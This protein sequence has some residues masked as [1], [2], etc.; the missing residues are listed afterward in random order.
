MHSSNRGP[1]EK[2]IEEFFSHARGNIS[3]A[4][5]GRGGFLLI[6][7]IIILVLLWLGTGIYVVQ[8]AEE[9]VVRTFGKFTNVTTAG[10]NY[11]F[12]WPI[13]TVTVV[14]VESIRRAE[15]G[16]RTT[17][18]DIKQE[19]LS[20]ALMLTEDENIVQVEL[21]IQYR[22]ANPQDFVFNVKRPEQVLLTSAEVALRSAVGQMTID[23]VITEER[24]R[25]QDETRAFLTR[26]LDDYGTGI[27]VT[28]VRLQ[29]ADPPE[30]VRDAFQEVVRAKADKERLINEAQ[31][32]QNDVVPRARGLKQQAIEEATAF[33]EQQVLRATGDAQRFLSVLEAYRLAP[34][35]TRERMHIEAIEGVLDDVRLVLLDR[36]AV[37]DQLLPFLPLTDLGPTPVGPSS[38]PSEV[39]V[40]PGEVQTQDPETSS[41]TDGG[42]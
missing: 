14:D 12:P 34:D 32:Y 15:I 10:L 27:Q 19:V 36:T 2:E 37:G 17:S 11:H 4:L 42:Q 29:V 30:E 23:D 1:N 38:Q 16:F 25:V 35:V 28:D 3:G 39:Q 5:S 22:V 40:A 8:P 33:K 13:Q 6:I 26:L 31:A 18:S 7:A 9:G 20:E 21:L 24:A 41:L